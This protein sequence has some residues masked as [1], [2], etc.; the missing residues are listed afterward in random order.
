M[1]FLSHLIVLMHG[2]LLYWIGLDFID[3]LARYPNIFNKC[4]HFKATILDFDTQDNLSLRGIL[5]ET[6]NLAKR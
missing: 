6:D 2:T 5:L 1:N 3:C 4:L